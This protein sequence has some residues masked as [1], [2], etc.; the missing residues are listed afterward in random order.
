MDVDELLH[1]H[2]VNADQLDPAPHLPAWQEMRDHLALRAGYTICGDTCHSAWVIDTGSG[3]RRVGLCRGHTPGV[4]S[5]LAA[6]IVLGRTGA[7][8]A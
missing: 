8:H 3:S 4:L 7:V 5:E 1:R 2:G 6:P